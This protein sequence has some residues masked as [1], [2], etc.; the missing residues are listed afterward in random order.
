MR[1][2]Y[3]YRASLDS[4]DSGQSDN[5]YSV[6]CQSRVRPKCVFGFGY[7]AEAD[8][9]YGFCLVSATA[10]VAQFR[11]RVSESKDILMRGES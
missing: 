3:F 4:L 11:F 7:G 9:T 5:D 10:K 6:N 8:L 1:E 2:F